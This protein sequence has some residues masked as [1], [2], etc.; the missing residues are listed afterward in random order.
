MIVKI[1]IV[2]VVAILFIWAFVYA[3]GAGYRKRAMEDK[4]SLEDALVAQFRAEHVANA[5]RRRSLILLHVLTLDSAK[6]AK[7]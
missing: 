3:H 6:K 7:S 1:V 2:A 5:Y 4:K